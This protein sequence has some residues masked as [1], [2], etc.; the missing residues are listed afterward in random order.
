MTA[1]ASR[2]SWWRTS[3]CALDLASVQVRHYRLAVEDLVGWLAVLFA[4]F[5]REATRR[6]D[7]AS[8]V[9][10]WR[11]W[12]DWRS[13]NS[14]PGKH[15]PRWPGTTK[16]GFVGWRCGRSNQEARLFSDWTE[17]NLTN[18]VSATTIL[19]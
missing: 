3:I 13:T 18:E 6:C 15:Q 9:I 12:K 8:I 17:R 5:G 2:K 7:A 19:G 14:T 4:A 10:C 11:V 16:R 1:I